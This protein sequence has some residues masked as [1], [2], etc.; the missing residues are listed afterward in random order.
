MKLGVIARADDR[1]LGNQTW[2]VCRHLDPE[3]VLV[4]TVPGSER[5]GFKTHLERFPGATVV[6]VDDHTWTLPQ[7][8][9]RAWLEGLDVVYTAETFYDA[10]IP[11]WA[12]GMGV[13]TVCHAN[14]EF[15]KD[16]KVNPTAWWA[17]TPWRLE[18]LPEGTRVVPMP[19]PIDRWP[20]PNMRTPVTGVLHVAGR[21]AAGDRNGTN[22]VIEAA[23]LIDG[24][25]TIV[26]QS[27]L[28]IPPN[29]TRAEPAANYWEL[30]E[31]HTALLMPRR[32]GG[33]CLPVIEACGA[34][35]VPIMPDVSPNELWPHVSIDVGRRS[36]SIRTPGGLLATP[37][38][39]PPLIADAVNAV[40]A[41]GGVSARIKA[42][43]WAE[44]HSWEHEADDWRAALADAANR[45]DQPRRHRRPPTVAVVVPF[46]PGSCVHR[47]AAWNW[48]RSRYE[49]FHS[50][51]EIVTAAAPAGEAWS[52][53]TAL[54]AAV[55][56]TDAEILVVADADVFIDPDALRDAVALAV[57]EPWV[58]PHT[59]VLRL[60][61]D[62]TTAVL[63]EH[64][65]WCPQR[66]W[67]SYDRSPYDGVAGGGLAVMR[68]SAWNAVGGMDPAFV[69]WGYEDES[70][71]RALDTLVGP[72]RRLT[73]PL[74]HLWHPPQAN[75]RR[76]NVDNEARWKSYRHAGGSPVAMRALI[77][78][79]EPP[80]LAAGDVV[81]FRCR[82][83][84]F[85]LRVGDR[86]VR[87]ERGLF[88]TA[89][90][91]FIE[92]LRLHPRVEEVTPCAR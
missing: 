51:W 67:G 61:P 48:V 55:A 92:A 52:K 31:G 47:D 50:P 45:V 22:A 72:H 25:V 13:A 90:P 69:G 27:H 82:G 29:I 81:T 87:F 6:A 79:E 80:D 68:R 54:A 37:E 1:G 11:E 20:A 73:G 70:F 74:W 24:T 83:S 17:P 85:R 28:D 3:R 16:G 64:P 71:G 35:L 39:S 18:H 44:V 63:G 34:G 10:R 89:D 41:D 88:E 23:G 62:H 4:V 8:D 15:Y 7:A 30:Y 78:G 86:M 14:P 77:F 40:L 46:T 38:I 36:S 32:Y 56:A 19:C 60:D 53:G 84:R 75:Y 5:Q 42:R 59:Q 76:A 26:A 58:V 49:A 9:V 66:R 2:E 57:T 33:L 65:T 12:T 21:I 43:E 91:E